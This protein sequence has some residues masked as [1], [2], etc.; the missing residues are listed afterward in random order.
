MRFITPNYLKNFKCDGTLCNSYC[1]REWKIAVDEET[2]NKYEC[3]PIETREKV[4]KNLREKDGNYYPLKLK[5]DGLCPFLREDLLCD[6][7]KNYGEDY[8]SNVCYSYPRVTVKVSDT[9]FQS[10]TL[11]CPVAAELVLFAE[12]IFFE[13]KEVKNY[14]LGWHSDFETRENLNNELLEDIVSAGLFILKDNSISIENRLKML[15]DF[16]N[17]AD[18]FNDNEKELNELLDSI[19]NN[20]FQQK[21]MEENNNKIGSVIFNEK[22]FLPIIFKLYNV[23]YE[24]NFDDKKISELTKIYNENFDN[25]NENLIE[26]NEGI[27]T[28]YLLNEFFMR[29]YPY[30]F[31][32]KFSA[33]IK[34]FIL[35]W[36]ALK[37]ALF[38]MYM[39]EGLDKENLIFCVRRVVE[40][41]DHGKGVVKKILD[42]AKEIE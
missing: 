18:S 24:V 32:Q 36:Y 5:K 16:Y 13:E 37:F 14:R 23:L 39:K 25:F 28:N 9:I 29:L 15:V 10:L 35:S 20:K 40:R 8:L 27:F 17:K 6:L 21:F 7:Q 34:T 38:M 41:I 3:L 2:K 33:N 4:L 12:N 42:L 19:E 22:D 31:N 1:C 26:N 30:A 11:S